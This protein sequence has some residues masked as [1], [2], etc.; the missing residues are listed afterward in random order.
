MSREDKRNK[1]QNQGAK[2]P[3]F[4]LIGTIVVGLVI[5]AGIFMFGGGKDEVVNSPYIGRNIPQAEVSH[6]IKDGKVLVDESELTNKEFIMFKVDLQGKPVTLENGSSFAYLPVLAY[7][8]PSGKLMGAVSLC[9][10]CSG[11]SFTIVENTL[12]CNACGTT[13][14]LETL[15]GISGGCPDHPPAQLQV[16]IKDG[17]LVFDENEIRTWTARPL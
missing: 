15:K 1:F 14:D 3:N 7:K 8:T 13:W 12:Y 11:E 9:E 4:V 5:M 16:E 6:E 10:P 17:K 2:K